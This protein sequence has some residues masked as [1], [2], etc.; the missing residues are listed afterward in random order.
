MRIFEGNKYSFTNKKDTQC[1]AET[2]LYR[3]QLGNTLFEMGNIFSQHF[4][5]S[6]LEFESQG[7]VFRKKITAATSL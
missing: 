7:V 6:N 1:K 2:F 3:Q 4:N 5:R